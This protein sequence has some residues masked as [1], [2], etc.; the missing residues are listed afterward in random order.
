[1]QACSQNSRGIQADPRRCRVD[2]WLERGG[3]FPEL[4]PARVSA[5][6]GRH[7]AMP[8]GRVPP[9]FRQARGRRQAAERHPGKQHDDEPVDDRNVRSVH[10]RMAVTTKGEYGYPAKKLSAARRML[11]LR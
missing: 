3:P 5:T 11:M 8:P 2:T 1:M 6:P 4:R 10:Q 7:G 9:R